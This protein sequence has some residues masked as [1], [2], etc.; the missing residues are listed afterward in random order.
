MSKF[1]YFAN[2][3][4]IE[5]LKSE[6]KRLAMLYHPDRPNG[7]LRTMQEINNEYEQLFPLLKNKHKKVDN[8]GNTTTYTA[9]EGT[10]EDAKEFIN[11]I[12]ELFKFKNINIELVGTWLWV[13]G[14]TKPISK[15][16]KALGFFYNPKRDITLWM[17]KPAGEG[18]CRYNRKETSEELKNK[19]GCKTFTSVKNPTLSLT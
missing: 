5:D 11:I 13:T 14:E 19:Y 9:T 7:D 1:V 16:L 2:C 4:T 12:S 18:K 10:T 3:N 15:N 17:L 8:E 6:Y